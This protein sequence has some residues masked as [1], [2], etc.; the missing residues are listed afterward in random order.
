MFLSQAMVI[1]GEAFGM[2]KKALVRAGYDKTTAHTIHK[3]A[4]IY[5]GRCGAPRKQERSREKATTA[6]CSFASLQA[7]ER[8]VAKL[9]KKH[10]WT[11]REAL[12]PYGRD[13]TAINAEGARLLQEYTRA[14]NPEKRLT[15]RAIPNSTFATL[16]LTAESSRVKQ[17]FDRAQ[18]TD[19]KCPADGLI[20]LALAANDGELP[21]VA[22][23]LMV[24]PFT[25]PYVHVTEVERGKFVFSMT[26]GATISGEEIVRAK[27][28]EERLV[29]LVSP[30]GPRD[31]GIY[32]IEM[33]P[34]SRY[35][36]PLER[37]I[38]S[39]R[40]PVCAWP[41]CSKPATK[42]QIHHIKPVKHGGKTVS[43]NLMVL[44]DYHNGIND[45]DLDKPKHGHMVRINGLE[46]WKPA[47][48]GPLKLNM[49]PCAQGG[50]VRLARMQLGMPIDPSPPG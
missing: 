9:P 42:S 19:T 18:A 47:F 24:I 34:E 4:G 8:F 41:G 21:P 49:N 29:A 31:F 10:A 27:L 13:I 48:G 30:L 28:A 35:A 45:D 39:T 1:A 20:K 46:Y 16:T 7:I 5:Y 23:P 3:L 33:T 12:V 11:I 43:E 25:M 6:G 40:N 26:N 22:I 17:I 36:D 15:Y 44:C 38:Q 32:R 37:F 14:E 50:A 2:S